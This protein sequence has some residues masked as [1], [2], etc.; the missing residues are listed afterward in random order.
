MTNREEELRSAL[1]SSSEPDTLK[2]ALELANEIL[3]PRGDYVEAE[4]ILLEV[5]GL[6][7]H[8]DGFIVQRSLG[9]LYIL[10]QEFPRAERF[11]AIAKSGEKK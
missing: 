7:T 5:L 11:L 10:M 2:A 8:S 1:T 4:T 3:I 6:Q 9:E